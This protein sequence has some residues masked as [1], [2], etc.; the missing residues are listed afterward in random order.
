MVIFTL[1]TALSLSHKDRIA[2]WMLFCKKKTKQNKT[3]VA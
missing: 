2:L 1:V 3:R